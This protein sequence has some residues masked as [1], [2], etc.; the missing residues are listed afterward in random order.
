MA[1]SKRLTRQQRA[2][3][4]ALAALPNDRIDTTDAPEIKDWSG[5]RRGV[6]YR[7][8]KRQLTLRVDADVIEWFRAHTPRGDGYQT[9]MNAALRDY[10]EARRKEG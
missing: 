2:E 3:L 10:V 9:R 5:A 8:V 7:P 6:L 4:D 1:N